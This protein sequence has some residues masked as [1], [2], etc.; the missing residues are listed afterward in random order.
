M[1]TVNKYLGL[2]R[3]IVIDNGENIS[4]ETE[5]GSFL[6]NKG[7][8]CGQEWGLTMNN[9][10]MTSSLVLTTLKIYLGR[11]GDLLL[12]A[13]ASKFQVIMKAGIAYLRTINNY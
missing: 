6:T 11:N 1:A 2:E 8:F 7:S 9:K 4:L 13:N 3:R 12:T 5:L 10:W